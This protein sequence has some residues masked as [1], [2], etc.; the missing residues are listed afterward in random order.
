MPMLLARLGVKR[1]EPASRRFQ[2]MDA[3]Q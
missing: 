3:G 1:D 2:A